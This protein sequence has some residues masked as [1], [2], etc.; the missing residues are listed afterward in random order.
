M[1]IPTMIPSLRV[2]TRAG[3]YLREPPAFSGAGH[4]VKRLAPQGCCLARDPEQREQCP[5][6][7]GTAPTRGDPFPLPG[8]QHQHCRRKAKFSWAGIS[9]TVVNRFSG[10]G[11]S[12]RMELL[13]L[14]VP[15]LP[16]P[17]SPLTDFRLPKDLMN[18]SFRLFQVFSHDRKNYPFCQ[19]RKKRFSYQQTWQGARQPPEQSVGIRMPEVAIP[20]RSTVMPLSWA[21][22]P[23]TPTQRWSSQP[24]S[25]PGLLT[26]VH[27]QRRRQ[28]HLPLSYRDWRPVWLACADFWKWITIK[29]SMRLLPNQ[30]VY[31]CV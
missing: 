5:E 27:K 16:L 9:A 25:G 10:E 4:A 14:L 21:S 28:Q 1:P 31:V 20:P 29:F 15:S 30:C 18:Y 26:K 2:L 11:V 8:W 13:R 3:I 6:T 19:E 23:Q 7:L 22:R 17:L 12:C 24:C